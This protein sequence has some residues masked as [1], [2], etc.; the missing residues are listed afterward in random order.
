MEEE[1]KKTGP[2]YLLNKHTCVCSPGPTGKFQETAVGWLKGTSLQT[3]AV[4]K[5]DQ[6]GTALALLPSA[7]LLP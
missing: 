7:L 4:S 3:W 5:P 1:K 2:F 6:D